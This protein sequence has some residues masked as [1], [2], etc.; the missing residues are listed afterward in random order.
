MVGGGVVV[1]ATTDS[2]T[3][4]P[5]PSRASYACNLSHVDDELRSFRSCLLWMCIDQ[6]DATYA[7]ISWSLFVLLL[8]FVSIA[9]HF[10]L[11]CPLIGRA[12]NVVVQLSLTSASGL[13]YLCLSTVVNRYSRPLPLP[14]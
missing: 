3:K 7:M 10:V 6:S 11:S 5:L 4:P 12:Y 1:E 14:R 13:S 8:V 9:S 2:S